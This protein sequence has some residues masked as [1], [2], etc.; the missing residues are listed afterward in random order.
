MI[1]NHDVSDKQIEN[2]SFIKFV[3]MLCVVAYHSIVFWSGNWFTKN[4]VFQSDFLNHLSQWL[5]SFHI[6]GFTLISGYIFSY[7]K[8]E[9]TGSLEILSVIKSKD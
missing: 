5:N 9:S 1:S 7:L 6:Y 4:P 8:G 2:C 3:L